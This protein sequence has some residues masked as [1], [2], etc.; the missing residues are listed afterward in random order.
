[1]GEKTATDVIL[2]N[3]K[4]LQRI[5]GGRF[6]FNL[7]LRWY[8]P[9]SG[10]IRAKIITLEPGHVVAELKD[11]RRIRNHL[12]SI[13]AIALTNFGELTSGLALLSSLSPG[14]RGI[15]TTIN[16]EFFQK[17]RG[18]L[19]AESHVTPPAVDNE[20]D[21]QVEAEIS[22]NNGETVARCR[23]SWHLGLTPS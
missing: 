23:V 5:P 7:F 18:T 15:P 10:G 13:H 16:I 12:N 9:Y 20:T 1:M 6:L 8:N 21:F 14:I 17:A 22:N 11:R 2:G 3:W 4:R 19:Y